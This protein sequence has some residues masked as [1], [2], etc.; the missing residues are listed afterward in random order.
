MPR[1]QKLGMRK[2]RLVMVASGRLGLAL[3]PIA[4]MRDDSVMATPHSPHL[5]AANGRRWIAKGTSEQANLRFRNA[6]A[7]PRASFT[8]T[9]CKPANAGC[10]HQIRFCNRANAVRIPADRIWLIAYPFCKLPDQACASASRKWVPPNGARWLANRICR[11][12]IRRGS[13][14]VCPGK[15][16]DL[17]PKASGAERWGP[18]ARR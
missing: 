7:C 14:A 3:R 16:P 12:A 15:R 13:Q 6:L 9:V 5:I 4:S 8:N 1:R 17:T 10:R 18:P 2:S 11:S